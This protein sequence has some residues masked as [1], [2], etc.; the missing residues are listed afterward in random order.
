MMKTKSNQTD[1]T[2]EI[3]TCRQEFKDFAYKVS[4]DLQAPIRSII[5]FSNFVV[6]S[7]RDK[8]TD[9]ERED[10]DMVVK[11]AKQAKDLIDALLQY[12]RL[13][14]AERPMV[15]V[16]LNDALTCLLRDMQEEINSQHAHINTEPL[17]EVLGDRSLLC[18]L[19]RH[20]IENSLKFHK[21]D[22]APVI[23]I[24]VEEDDGDWLFRITDN[25]I[26][27]DPKYHKGIFDMFRKLHA[28]SDYPGLG[29][30]L[31]FAKK[32]VELNHGTIGIDSALGQ[33]TTVWFKL[34]KIAA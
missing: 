23:H 8:M 12:S 6:A 30:G 24:S 34:P 19:W 21:K 10:L 32:I 17:P 15:K 11:A 3:A 29:A 26:G 27:I 5:G 4:H 9:Q 31:A 20:L 2:N 1:L 16:D 22:V 28:D 13:M 25:G 33:G 7:A 18:M 14:T